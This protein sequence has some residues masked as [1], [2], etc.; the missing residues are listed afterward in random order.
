MRL[1][2]EPERNRKINPFFR[3]AQPY[4]ETLPRALGDP[5]TTV[6]PRSL[7]RQTATSSGVAAGGI[8]QTMFGSPVQRPMPN[9]RCQTIIAQL[10]MK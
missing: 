3:L 8:L 6:G 1:Q 7:G 2:R 4:P 9:Q 5:F 10:L